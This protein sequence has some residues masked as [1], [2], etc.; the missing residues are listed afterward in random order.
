MFRQS[1]VTIS[2]VLSVFEYKQALHSSDI[3]RP[4]PGGTESQML[5]G[6]VN[7]HSLSSLIGAVANSDVFFF[8]FLFPNGN[9]KVLSFYFSL[10]LVHIQLIHCSSRAV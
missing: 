3:F 8:L 6:E 10:S 7:L 9:H 5:T 4:L 2:F 1:V